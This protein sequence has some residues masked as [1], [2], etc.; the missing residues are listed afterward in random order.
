MSSYASWTTTRTSAQLR[1]TEAPFGQRMAGCCY[2]R[3]GG[4]CDWCHWDL[5]IG[6]LDETTARL[7]VL[8]FR[9]SDVGLVLSVSAVCR[10]HY[11]IVSSFVITEG[12]DCSFRIMHR[13]L[14]ALDDISESSRVLCLVG[15][16]F[17]PEP[18]PVLLA[19][20][21]PAPENLSGCPVPRREHN[22]FPS[23]LQSSNAHEIY[24]PVVLS[25]RSA[26]RPTNPLVFPL[27]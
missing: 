13:L 27:G 10:T 17:R 1:P 7:D 20:A 2:L 3:I 19:R 8:L 6:L 4:L 23:L 21:S 26:E 18:E 9:D 14:T 22:V 5:H 11:R 24:K 15:S 16:P 25:V 12:I